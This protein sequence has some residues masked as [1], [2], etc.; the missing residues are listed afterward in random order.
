MRLKKWPRFSPTGDVKELRAYG[1]GWAAER[2]GIFAVG[3]CGG[4]FSERPG[5]VTAKRID[6]RLGQ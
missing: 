3:E 1:C 2:V 4:D 5:R 6:K